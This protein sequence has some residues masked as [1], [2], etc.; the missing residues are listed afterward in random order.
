MNIQRSI[1]LA[2][3]FFI[4]ASA[5]PAQT[6]IQVRPNELG[7]APQSDHEMTDDELVRFVFDPVTDTL[8]L[9]PGQKFR[10]VTIA[11]ST[12]ARN[13]TLFEQLNELDNQISI[14]AFTGSLDETKL[15]DLSSKQAGLM[16]EISASIARAKASFYK[17]LTPEQRTIV[18]A[19]YRLSEQSLGGLSN[20]GP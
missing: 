3:V 14:A 5:I 8:N 10:I 15:K 2:A 4:G 17:V 7:Q 11:G 16:S 13:E 12:L 18:L 1:L 20:V 6:I 19:Q 9:T